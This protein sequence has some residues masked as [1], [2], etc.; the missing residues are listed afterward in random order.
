MLLTIITFLIILSVLVFVH[1]FGHFLVAKKTGIA[2]EEFGFGLPPRIFGKKIGETVYSINLLPIGGFV[3]LAGEDTDPSFAK[4]SEGKEG[5]FWQKS[6]K[7]RLAVIVSGVIMNFLLAVFAFSVIYAKLGIPTKTDKVTIVGIAPGSPAQ[8]AGLKEGDIALS[9]GGEEIKNTQGFVEITQ[10]YAGK[11]M[12]LE[13]SREKDNPCKEKVLGAWPGLEISCKGENLVLSIVPR[14]APP[15]GEGPLGVAISQVEMK[16]Y[17]FWQMIPKGILE[18]FKE[19]FAWASLIVGAL[20]SMLWQLL[21]FGTVPKDVA[22]PVGIFQITGTVAK[23][24]IL[25][26]LQFLGI[27]SVN[28]AVI[29]ILPLPALDGGRLL[30][31]GIEAITGKR[32]H[33]RFERI[34]HTV[35]MMILLFLI[36]LVTIND[37]ARILSS[38]GF[39]AH[40]KSLLPF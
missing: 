4:A 10:K 3:K 21:R 5:M 2:V 30:F 16:F 8:E 34:V 1:E 9:A 22:G 35:G 15:D 25:S 17:P 19:A 31:L 14:E 28:L 36:L 40:L 23:T 20:A 37:I 27:L 26:V 12:S 6:K 13:I 18:G 24:G 32:S 11:P 7:V 29:N 38:S 33:A 39:A